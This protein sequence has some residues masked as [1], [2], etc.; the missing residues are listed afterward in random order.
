M[1]YKTGIVL[2]HRTRTACQVVM[3]GITALLPL[4]IAAV[5]AQ[6]AV[7][8]LSA[9]FAPPATPLVLTRTLYR[10]LAG[11]GQVVAMRRYAVRFTPEGDGY[12][13]DGNL[14][15]VEVSC[16]PQLAQ[17]AAIERQRPD[18]ALFPARLD[19][20]GMII[21][22]PAP[23][24]DPASRQRALQQVDAFIR[25]AP[26]TPAD[27]QALK[28]TAQGV[29]AGAGGS[30]WP[31][32]LFNPGTAERRESRTIVLADGSH[33]QIEVRTKATGLMA[34][35]LPGRVER[36]II[37]RLAGTERTI[38]TRLAGTERTTREVWTLAL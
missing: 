24:A 20:Q 22:D 30:A 3:A 15:S 27:R 37:T 31:V 25:R 18:T 36:T 28:D 1:L 33:G 29:L 14:I 6:A 2:P 8:A 38:I 32:F 11:G 35:G 17:I 9:V 12:R 34:S 23:P 10:P 5:D 26:A 13:L 16:P 4:A 7:Q 19:A 21:D